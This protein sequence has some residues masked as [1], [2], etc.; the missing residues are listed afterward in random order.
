MKKRFT[1]HD[2]A[3]IAASRGALADG[4]IGHRLTTMASWAARYQVSLPGCSGVGLHFVAIRVA[5]GWPR[6]G[7]I[8]LTREDGRRFRLYMTKKRW[9][10]CEV[11]RAFA[12]P[13]DAWWHSVTADPLPGEEMIHGN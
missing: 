9:K 11:D 6:R 7:S 3:R 12:E 13:T 10:G 2:V 8:F 1:D 4:P 5:K